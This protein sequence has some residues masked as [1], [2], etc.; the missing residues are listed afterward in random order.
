M[1]FKNRNFLRIILSLKYKVE[2]LEILIQTK[3]NTKKRK[4]CREK[5]GRKKSVK[6]KKEKHKATISPLIQDK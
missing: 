1:I 5:K 4:K 6:E 2:I 3:K